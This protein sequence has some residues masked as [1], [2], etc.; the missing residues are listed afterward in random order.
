[1]GSS[2]MFNIYGQYDKRTLYGVNWKPVQN[3][4][5]NKS[6]NLLYNQQSEQSDAPSDA[7]SVC[8]TDGFYLIRCSSLEEVNRYLTQGFTVKNINGVFQS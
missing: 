2:D 7:I 8:V 5:R 6:T 4:S 1:M 3:R